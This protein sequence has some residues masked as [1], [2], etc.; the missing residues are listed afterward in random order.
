MQKFFIYL[1]LFSVMLYGCESV[2]YL[3]SE[4]SG[5]AK[6][7][8]GITEVVPV[9]KTYPV[10]NAKLRHAV[11]ETLDE[12]GYIYNENMGR[13]TT[14]PKP[15]G[16]QSQFGFLGATYYSKLML[17]ISGSTIKFIARFNKDSNLT[18]DEQNIEYPE[19]E[20]ELRKEFYSELDKKLGVSGSNQFVSSKNQTVL[21]VQERLTELGYNPGPI[22]GLMGGKTIKAIV[23]FQKD[24]GLTENGKIDDETVNKLGI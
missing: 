3:K 10:S 12:Q 19:K 11:L 8:G 23:N 21:R 1:S 6:P 17:S 7:K 20:N 9:K 4:I 24:N 18:Q 5:D 22:D 2:N 13:I 15:I 16:D 14:E